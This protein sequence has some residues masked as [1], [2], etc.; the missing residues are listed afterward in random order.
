MKTKLLLGLVFLILLVMSCLTSCKTAE[1]SQQAFTL[2]VTLDN[3]VSGT[4]A[5]GTYSYSVNDTVDYSYSVKSGYGNL[6][7]NLDGTPVSNS[8]TFT[9]SSNHTLEVSADIDIRG[10]WTGALYK[11]TQDY[12]FQVIFGGGVLSGTTEGKND[13]LYG[14]GRGTFTLNGNEIVFTLCYNNNA[15]VMTCTGTLTDK[16]NQNGTFH[17]EVCG[18][19]EY[20]EWE[21]QRE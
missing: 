20:G 4:P 6:T 10:Q 3:G 18:F 2:T 13:W 17:V 1:D 11:G 8:G 16:D 15:D 21:L 5:S 14:T 12:Y 9:V 7:V 19:D